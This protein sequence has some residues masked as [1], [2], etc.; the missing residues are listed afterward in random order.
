[1]AMNSLAGLARVLEA[2]NNAIEL[3]PALAARARLP[4]QRMLDFTAV[5]KTAAAV[6]SLVPG[7]G[8]A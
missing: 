4:V 1:M 6:G 7:I 3:D 8:A 2:G 5:Q